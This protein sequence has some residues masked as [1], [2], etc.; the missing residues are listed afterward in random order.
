MKN[1]KIKIFK[2]KVNIQ[3]I[4]FKRKNK[5]KIYKTKTVLIMKKIN[6]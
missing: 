2:K 6:K 1:N 4:I 3:Y 5:F